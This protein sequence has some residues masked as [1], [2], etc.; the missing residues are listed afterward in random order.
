[1]ARFMD[2]E[3]LMGAL[4]LQYAGMSMTASKEKARG[5]TRE[6]LFRWIDAQAVAMEFMRIECGLQEKDTEDNQ[7]VAQ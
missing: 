4:A 5:A 1:M 7:D 2:T 3:M 6:Q